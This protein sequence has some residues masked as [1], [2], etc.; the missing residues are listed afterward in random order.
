MKTILIALA[1]AAALFLL[2]AGTVGLEHGRWK[3]GAVKPLITV[4]EKHFN[5]SSVYNGLGF[6]FVTQYEGEEAVSGEFWF[7]NAPVDR[8]DH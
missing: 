7:L 1:A 6:S 8:C 2:W 5:G 4:S 3:D